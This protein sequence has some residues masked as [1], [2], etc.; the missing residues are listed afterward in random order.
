[1]A[2]QL[3][4]QDLAPNPKNPRR[5]SEGKLKQLSQ[6]LEEFGDL[7]GI[8][9]NRRTKQL[10]G[11]HQRVKALPRGTVIKVTKAYEKPTRTGT[12][13]DGYVLVKGERFKYR[14]V[15]WDET[16]EKAANIAAN[17]HGGEWDLPQLS[18]WLSE[19]KAADFNMDLTGFDQD[20]LAKHIVEVEKLE[21]AGDPDEVPEPPK[22]A[23]TKLGDVYVLGDHRLL[24]GDST[25]I[26]D[27][28]KLM[29]GRKAGM[30]FT[31][32]PYGV[33][34][35]SG[36]SKG[37]TAT[38]FDVL[39]NDDKF[40][41]IA[42]VIWAVMADNTACFVWTSHHV[43]PKWRDH[44]SEFYKST[45]IWHKPGGGIGDL[46]GNYATNYEMC[47]FCVKGRP[48]FR[49]AR[50]AAVWTVS[51]DAAVDYVHPTQKPVELAERAIADFSDKGATI[52][53]LFG[54][55]GSTLIACE[56]A[57]RPCFMM[58]LDPRYCDVIVAR[59]E[60]YTGQKA[61]L[62]GE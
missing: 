14:E 33:S 31:D 23:K 42:P 62:I 41:D 11:G 55:S 6:A 26:D 20:E 60:K 35:Q 46:T 7:S 2:K 30:V 50:G 48:T 36:M 3:T 43:Y 13:A 51:K 15:D 59:W 28:E 27:V 16:R 9:F 34:F 44:F 40:L 56:K 32:P 47:L 4:I 52:L 21:P 24:C 45:I 38:R 19:L 25:S 58:E 29:A 12:L 10:V 49:G 54:G 18:E 37:G 61:E 39:E 17:Q 22:I 53:D 5:I 57:G 1:M 8:V